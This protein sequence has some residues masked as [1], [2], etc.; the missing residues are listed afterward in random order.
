MTDHVEVSTPREQSAFARAA[1][2]GIGFLLVVFSLV[3]CVRRVARSTITPRITLLRAANG[4]HGAVRIP[5]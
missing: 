1:R 4:G 2:L 3:T 5:R